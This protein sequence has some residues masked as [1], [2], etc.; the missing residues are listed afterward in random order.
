LE[1]LKEMEERN[2]SLEAEMQAQIRALNASMTQRMEQLSA[3]YQRQVDLLSL[4]LTQTQWHFLY[5]VTA[6]VAF[7]VTVI[8]LT[9]VRR[10]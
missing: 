2:E 6:F 5:V 9:A 3:D 10:P 1:L 7:S 8:L 4:S